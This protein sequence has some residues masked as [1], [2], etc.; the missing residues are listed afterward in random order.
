MAH[1]NRIPIRHPPE[2][3]AAQFSKG[4]PHAAHIGGKPTYH[5]TVNTYTRSPLIEVGSWSLRESGRSELKPHRV[6]S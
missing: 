1:P 4:V 3:R 6:K 5:H 2:E